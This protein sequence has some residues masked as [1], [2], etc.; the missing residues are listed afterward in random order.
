MR[1]YQ[2][3]QDLLFNLEAT[4]SSEAKRKWKESIKEEWNYECAYCGS[5]DD[6]TLDHLNYRNTKVLRI[7][8]SL[9]TARKRVFR[10]LQRQ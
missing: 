6:L 9:E 4:K 8:S 3:S 2:T 10:L 7:P 5:S 1:L